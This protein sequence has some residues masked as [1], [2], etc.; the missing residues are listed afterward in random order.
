M[1]EQLSRDGTS[2]TADRRGT[3]LDD[4]AAAVVSAAAA[5]FVW[6]LWSQVIGVELEVKGF[7]GGVQEVGVVSVVLSTVAFVLVGAALL[8][9]M[10]RRS[11][12]GLRWWTWIATAFAVVSLMS[13]TSALSARAVVALVSIHVVVAAVA[14]LW[15]RHVHR[16]VDGPRERV[17]ARGR[18]VG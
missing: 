5:A 14:I 18:A 11:E 16:P 3:F 4:L 8:R 7:G 12:A 17:A 10:Q 9:W 15:L 1:T 13:P 2:E 6:L